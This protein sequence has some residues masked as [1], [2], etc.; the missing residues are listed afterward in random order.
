M[1]TQG[2]TVEE[3]NDWMAL[4]PRLMELIKEAVEGISPTF[5]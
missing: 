5:A 3:S 1:S 4:E 2:Q